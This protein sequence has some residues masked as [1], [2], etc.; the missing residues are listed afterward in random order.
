[1]ASS[2]LEI[3][4]ETFPVVP[5]EH[6]VNDLDEFERAIELASKG[7]IEEGQLIDGREFREQIIDL[8]SQIDDVLRVKDASNDSKEP[9]QTATSADENSFNKKSA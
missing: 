4:T 6:I 7:P 1:M 8:I 5:L 2:R 9:L 3:V